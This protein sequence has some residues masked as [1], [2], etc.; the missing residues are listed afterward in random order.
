MG[1]F[2]GTLAVADVFMESKVPVVIA[3]II[4]DKA[5]NTA[6]AILFLCV[7]QFLPLRLWTIFLS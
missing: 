1:I 6:W 2:V 3:E 5:H 4:V 7:L